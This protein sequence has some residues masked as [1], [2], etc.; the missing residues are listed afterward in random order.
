MAQRQSRTSKSSNNI[1]F[2]NPSAPG[3][4]TF[5]I[6]PSEPTEHQLNPLQ[7]AFLEYQIA[8]L[9]L[10]H[11]FVIQEN[12]NL[13]SQLSFLIQENNNLRSQAAALQDQVEIQQVVIS[14]KEFI[15]EFSLN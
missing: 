6:G 7:I 13:R 2:N 14:N 8:E 10:Q 3:T 11:S 5:R 1:S 9:K 12:N 15:G 4:H